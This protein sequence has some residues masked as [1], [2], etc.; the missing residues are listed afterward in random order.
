MKVNVSFSF[1]FIQ[2]QVT[3]S[4]F[5]NVCKLVFSLIREENNDNVFLKEDIAGMNYTSLL[6]STSL[7]SG[8]LINALS[9]ADPQTQHEAM[10]YGMGTIKLL[11]SNPQLREELSQKDC[12]RM[13]SLCLQKCSEV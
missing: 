2:M 7:L 1:T 10:V 13:M 11:A 9:N 3:G 12:V 4:N 5:I 6:S 8:S